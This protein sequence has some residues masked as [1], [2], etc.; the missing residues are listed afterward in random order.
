M[1][2]MSQQ[3]DLFGQAV[4]RGENDG[5]ARTIQGASYHDLK[6]AAETCGC[7]TCKGVLE[8]IRNT[9]IARSEIYVSKNMEREKNWWARENRRYFIQKLRDALASPTIK[10]NFNKKEI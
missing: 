2:Q 3:L 9:I 10:H 5:D 4:E 7:I 6:T 1:A 8:N